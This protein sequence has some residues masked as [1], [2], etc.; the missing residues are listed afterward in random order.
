ML[1]DHNNPAHVFVFG[2]NPQGRHGKGAA[3]HA[4]RYFNAKYGQASGLQGRSYGIITKDLRRG[5]RSVSLSS[6][7]KQLQVLREFAESNQQ[8]VFFMTKIGTGL[9]G[10]TEKEIKSLTNQIK[11][12]VNVIL[13]W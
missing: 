10:F 3:L 2:S 5:K 13:P 1:I 11:W 6:I 9:A 12:P 7:Y 4:K 8:L